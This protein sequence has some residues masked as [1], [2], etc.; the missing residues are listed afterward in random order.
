MGGTVPKQFL[1]IGGVPILALTLRRFINAASINSIVIVTEDSR[2][3]E[4]QNYVAEL[5]LQKKCLVVGGGKERQ[6]S[7]RNGLS[8]LSNDTDIVIVH[9]GVRPFIEPRLIDESVTQA[10]KYGACIVAV[11]ISDTVKKAKDQ[12][13]ISQ[14]VERSGLWAAQTPQTFRYDILKRAFDNAYATNFYGTDEASLVERIGVPIK[15]L[16]GERKNIKITT[17]EDLEL[18]EK[19][20]GQESS[21]RIGTGYDLHKLVAGRKL[22]IGGVHID[23]EKGLFGHSDADVLLHA[24]LDAMLGAAAMGDIGRHFPDT[25]P[26]YKNADS[27]QL[28]KRAALLIIEN[29]FKIMNVDANIIAEQ[30]K[31]APH[32]EA[33][34]ANVSKDLGISIDRVSIKAKT[35]E[36]MDAIGRGEAIAAQAIVLISC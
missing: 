8:A 2:V 3:N 21:M 16:K 29:G 33:M 26:Q 20:V 32:I 12:D 13:L 36:G 4:T 10:A 19:I 9:D 6:D 34:R 11:P 17:P 18:A 5:G 1:E 15:L 25:D 31:M 22:I 35:N 24:I 30:P 7:V 23:H 14:T 28:L 27:R